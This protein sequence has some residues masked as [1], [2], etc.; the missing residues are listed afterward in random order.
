MPLLSVTA[1]DIDAAGVALDAELPPAWLDGELADADVK[2][3]S[4]GRVTAR[5][6]RTGEE[7]VVRGRVKAALQI[8]CARC[9]EPSML[10]VDTDLTLLLRPAKEDKP[11]KHHKAATIGE[12]PKPPARPVE[13]YE[14]SS[15]EADLDTYDGETVVLDGFVREALLLEVPNFPLCSE[16]CPGIQPPAEPAP[17]G[18][19]HL[20]PRLSPLAALKVKLAAAGEPAQRPPKKTKKKE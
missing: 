8:P 19:P 4:P 2:A 15:G 10:D 14:F 6:S 18:E 11:G 16:G 20:D 9:T 5:L 1:N 7:I 13:E 3:R 12:T 17:P